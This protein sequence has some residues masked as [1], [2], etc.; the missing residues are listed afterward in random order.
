MLPNKYFFIF[1]LIVFFLNR[2]MVSYKDSFTA[3]PEVS[4]ELRKTLRNSIFSIILFLVFGIISNTYLEEILFREHKITDHIVLAVLLSVNIFVF[5]FFAMIF[6][7]FKILF[8]NFTEK[9]SEI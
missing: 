1:A 7:F 5:A 2:L 4:I 8:M 3:S 6:C 9:K